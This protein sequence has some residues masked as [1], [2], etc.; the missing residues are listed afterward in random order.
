MLSTAALMRRCLHLDPAKRTSAV[1]LL[2]DPWFTGGRLDMSKAPF[3]YA[4]FRVPTPLNVV[5]WQSR[6]P[7]NALPMHEAMCVLLE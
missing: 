6:V 7:Y 4:P 3:S 1:D 2:S 5:I